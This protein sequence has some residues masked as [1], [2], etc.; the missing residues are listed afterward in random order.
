MKKR[1]AINLGTVL[2]AVTLLS[3]WACNYAKTGQLAKDAAASVLVAQQVEIQ[4][5]KAGYIDDALH[6]SIKNEML[7]LADAG[8]RLDS[9]IS[10]AHSASG[11]TAE[12]KVMNTLLSDLSQNKLAGI[13]DQNTKLALQAAFLTIQTTLDNIAAFGGK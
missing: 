8:A 13:K 4:A 10:Q 6:Q 7:S 2:I 5:H 3:G 11:A 9:A 1:I 12:L